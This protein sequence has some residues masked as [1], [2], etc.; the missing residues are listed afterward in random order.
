MTRALVAVLVLAGCNEPL[1]GPQPDRPV[2]LKPV[3]GPPPSHR[4]FVDPA[5][6]VAKP[7]PP[8]A[9][10]APPAAAP[11]PTQPAPG[12]TDAVAIEYRSSGGMAVTTVLG[13]ITGE[14]KSARAWLVVHQG[15][16][17]KTIVLRRGTLDASALWARL[18]QL[19]WQKLE[20]HR[21][22]V[23]DVDDQTLVLRRG[24]V[25]HTVALRIGFEKKGAHPTTDAVV[26]VLAALRKL[27]AQKW[28][29][30][31]DP[32]LKPGT[33]A[34]KR[35][36]TCVRKARGEYP[37]ADGSSL[38]ALFEAKGQLLAITANGAP[39]VVTA[40]AKR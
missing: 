29:T 23:T 4:P 38:N 14:G 10:E 9:P 8:P 22:P 39:E 24:A 11:A 34:L 6:A 31:V 17:E 26:A 28:T 40:T 5:K 7:L 32:E 16:R 19:Q 1:E 35:G 12:A 18:E 27:P 30:E 13:G 21:P 3:E 20:D 15:R 25:T 2:Q 37:C 36:L 33:L